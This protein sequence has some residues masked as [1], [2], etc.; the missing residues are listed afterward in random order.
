MIS[1]KQNENVDIL[2]G[3]GFS[4]AEAILALNRTNNNVET[5]AYLLRQGGNF[6]II[7][8]FLMRRRL[9]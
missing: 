4:K 9:Y 6:F 5:A 3:M 7:S 8:H 1:L 2:V